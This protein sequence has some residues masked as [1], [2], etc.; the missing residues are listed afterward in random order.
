MKNL[1]I[2]FFLIVFSTQ[3]SAQT[4]KFENLIE[5]DSLHTLYY[6]LNIEGCIKVQPR[7]INEF[8]QNCPIFLDEKG[9]LFYMWLNNNVLEYVVLDKNIEID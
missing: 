8:N 1:I 9:Y 5:S 4:T 7:Y 6:N 3:L 2:L